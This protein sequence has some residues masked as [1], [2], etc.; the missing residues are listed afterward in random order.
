M[1][2]QRWIRKIIFSK[3]GLYI[4][5]AGSMEPMQFFSK[6]EMDKKNHQ[7]LYKNESGS[8]MF[9]NILNKL[10]IRYIY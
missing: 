7:Q 1:A 4:S 10:Y 9:T 2:P 8:Y 5:A 6:G 3:L